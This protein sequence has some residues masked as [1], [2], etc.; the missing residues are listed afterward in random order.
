MKRFILLFCLS[1]LLSCKHESKFN[2][3]KDLYQFSEKI[4]NGDTIEINVDYSACMYFAHEVF[5]FVKQND[6]LFLQTHSEINSFGKREQNLP[7]TFYNIPASDQL[8]FENYFKYL[9]KENKPKED[10]RS[11]LVVIY[12]KNRDQSKSFFDDGLQDK[13]KKLD[14]FA[15]IRE[16]IYPNDTFFKSPEPPPPPPSRKNKKAPK[17][18]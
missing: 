5:T 9:K 14:K 6:T 8:S 11:P 16:K 1:L 17:I 4:E 10:F 2:L 3:E 15:L 7:K 12:Y 13:F 18:N